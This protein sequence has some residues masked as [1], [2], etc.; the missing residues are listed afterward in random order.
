MKAA[1]LESINNIVFREIDTPVPGDGEVRVRVCYTGVCGSDVPRALEGRVHSFPLVLG[2][3]FS[4]YVDAV[5]AGVDDSLIGKLVAGVPLE[6]CGSCSDC[7]QGNFSLCEQYG[8][9]GSRS[10]GSMAEYVVVPAENAFLV[11]DNV[12]EIQA[13]FFEPATVALH[14][15]ELACVKPG[16]TAIVLGGGTIGT[17]LAQALRGY[18]IR[19]VVVTN[20]KERNLARLRA[21]GVDKAVLTTEEGWQEKACALVG[22][23]GF[24]YV[25]DAAG[26]PETILDAFDMAGT[27]A[28]VC[29]VG[30]PSRDVRFT[31]SQWESL[32]RKELTIKGSWMSYSSP[33]PGVEWTKA[34]DL[35]ASGIMKVV[36]EM[37]DEV[38]PLEQAQEALQRFSVPGGVNG[39]IIIDSCKER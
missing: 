22:C 38:Y 21:A 37:I 14:G 27:R 29:F 35:F 19:D 33:W 6:P 31:A 10:F 17:L 11:G 32:N 3:E 4:G 24:D 26:T 28:T 15:I 23:R 9:V 1:V 2:H 7:A 39:K 34:S 18:G 25:F 20:R 5:G 8:F 12:S 30:T 13:A 36:D 16:A